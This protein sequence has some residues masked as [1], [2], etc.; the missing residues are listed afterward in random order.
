MAFEPSAVAPAVEHVADVPQGSSTPPTSPSPLRPKYRLRFTKAGD[1]R[2]VSHIDLMHCFERLLRRAG[3]PFAS[4]QGFHPKPR[5][6]FAQALALGVLG[7]NEVV[8][9]ELAT[10]LATDELLSRLNE[11]A[12]PGL[13]FTA[14]VAIKHKSSL[15]VRRAFYRLLLPSRG[16]NEV[17]PAGNA[18][19]LP[20]RCAALLAQPHHVITRTRPHQRCLDLRPYIAELTATATELNMALW[21]TPSG[22]ARPEEV[23]QALGLGECLEAGAVLERTHLEIMDELPEDQRS[24]PVVGQDSAPAPVGQAQKPAP[25]GLPTALIPN[26]LS[27]DT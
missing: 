27:F 16:M 10:P 19:D 15:Q 7:H 18:D 5:I 6:V 21:I 17:N 4:T 13:T 24:L 3:L 2:L 8:E 1:L 11:H 26:P 23:V 22:A 25:R 12:P 14:C 9:I 20:Q